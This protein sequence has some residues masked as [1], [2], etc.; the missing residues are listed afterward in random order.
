[1]TLRLILDDKIL[2]LPA[3][4]LGSSRLLGVKMIEA[5]LAGNYFPIF[6]QLQSFCE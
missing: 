4:E 5:G 2:P 1:M 3:G 6:C